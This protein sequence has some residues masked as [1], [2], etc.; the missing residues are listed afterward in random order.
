MRLLTA[1]LSF[2][3]LLAMVAGCTSPS[4][5]PHQ[6]LSRGGH[7]LLERGPVEQEITQ[8]YLDKSERRL[9]LISGDAPVREYQIDLGFSPK[10]HKLRQG[11]GRTP[12]GLYKINRRND[13]SAFHL[14]LGLSYPNTE[15]RR[16]AAAS[17]VSPG[18]DIFIHGEAG[19]AEKSGT[20]W[21]AGCIALPDDRMEEIF[22]AV[23]IGT[24]ILIVP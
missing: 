4:S 18:G 19:Y 12:E 7:N 1:R 16:Q 11:D 10:G 6:F 21:T 3:A 15:D 20:D 2:V 24:P 23:K 14:S 5:A 22:A 8:L 13:Q 9:V 17:G